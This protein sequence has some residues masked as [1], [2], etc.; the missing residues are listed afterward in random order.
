[1]T[2]LA[3]GYPATSA[4]QIDRAGKVDYRHIK[5]SHSK[6]QA[7]VRCMLRIEH[8]MLPQLVRAELAF[9]SSLELHTHGLW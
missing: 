5:A 7:L 6:K 2:S 8:L 9:S 1:M 4:N 3:R